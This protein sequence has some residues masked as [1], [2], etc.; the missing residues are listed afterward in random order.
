MNLVNYIAIE[1]GLS[2]AADCSNG[3]VSLVGGSNSMEGRVEMCIRNI[4]TSVCSSLSRDEER[5][6][7]R[8]NGYLRNDTCKRYFHFFVLLTMNCLTSK[9]IKQGI[10]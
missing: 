9:T 4:W 1:V 8:Q 5:V 7:C 3:D 10:W 6:V 2:M